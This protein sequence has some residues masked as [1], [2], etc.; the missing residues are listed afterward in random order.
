M[1]AMSNEGS[2]PSLSAEKSLWQHLLEGWRWA[3]IGAVLMFVFA[4]IILLGWPAGILPDLSLPYVFA[5]DGLAVLWLVQRAME[6]WVFNN[7]RSGFPFGSSF[8]D[9]PGSDSGSFL[10]YKILGNL[11]HSNF[12]AFD[13]YLL[14]S[15][16]IVFVMS[17]VVFRSF[18]IRKAYSAMAAALFTFAPF[19]FSRFFYGHDLYLWYFGVPLFFY[20]GK[21][22]YLYGRTHWGLSNPWRA[23]S[24][25]LGVVSLSCFGVYFAFFGLIV[26]AV[27][28]AAGAFRLRSIRPVLNTV[29]FCAAIGL[30]VVVNL[31]PNI[32]DRH[33]R[34]VNPEIAARVPWE[35]EMYALKTIHLLL[36]QPDHRIPA[37]GAFARNYD[38]TFPLS[39]T[40]SSLGVV[41][42]IGFLAII[43]A[44]G[45]ALSGRPSKPLFSL[46]SI[47]VLSLLLIST[48]GGF[49][50]LFALLVS[51]LIRG[52][53]RISIFIDFGAVL[54]FA[55]L[56]DGAKW[57]NATLWRPAIAAACIATVGLLDQTP[58]SYRPA[59]EAGMRTASVDRDF[60]QKIEAA[61]PPGSAIYDLPYIAFP[62][63]APVQQLSVYDLGT[64]F[65]NSKT[66]KWSFG[67]MAGRPGDLF[68]RGLSK[69]SIPEQIAAI[70]KLGFSGVYVDRRG[71]ADHGAAIVTDLTAALGAGPTLQRPDGQ[72]VFFK[73]PQ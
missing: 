11:A 14:F 55:L 48:V 22:L 32:I 35:T 49:N 73:M 17:F 65:I 3:F 18:D 36:P 21:N 7:P 1:H 20:Y 66:L 58:T 2:P 63:S 33:E 69:K 29:L 71:F 23:G 40:T 41:G 70:K 4:S 43:L 9:Y 60:I 16:P 31:L 54:A 51:P 67:G 68:Y 25:L 5:G 28:G 10:A 12:A 24:M 47:V 27:C 46:T 62:E 61:M 8:L 34:G 53:D 6:G 37:L 57:V 15:F 44:A 64:G 30:G 39:N 38:A 13:L 52:W 19:H 50:V 72:V 56:I 45:A 42:T 59:V 26:L